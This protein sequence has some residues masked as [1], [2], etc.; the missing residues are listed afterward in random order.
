MPDALVVAGDLV[1]QRG[2]IGGNRVGVASSG[3]SGTSRRADVVAEGIP[4]AS[5]GSPVSTSTR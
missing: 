1:A 2:E 4:I 3:A 5:I